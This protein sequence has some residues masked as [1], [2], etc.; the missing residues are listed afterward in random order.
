MQLK[1]RRPRF[2]SILFIVFTHWCYL[3]HNQA[4]RP[5]KC[6]CV[7]LTRH[8]T[9][10]SHAC[11]HFICERYRWRT[12]TM[13]PFITQ[14]V[15]AHAA[16]RLPILSISAVIQMSW[17]MT[18]SAPTHKRPA[19]LPSHPYMHTDRLSAI[20]TPHNGNAHEQ[21][22]LPNHTTVRVSNR[23]INTQPRW[24]HPLIICSASSIDRIRKTE[25][26]I[27]DK[28]MVAAKKCKSQADTDCYGVH[29]RTT[30]TIAA[31]KDWTR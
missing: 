27:L 21:C 15:Y 2:F 31:K 28:T 8:A 1:E 5:C 30:A 25:G 16:D 3:P 12:R 23:P 19:N 20:V 24:W 7:R 14:Y 17:M 29:L 18:A 4:K 6:A 10:H 22:A 13:R 26:I 9:P 11:W